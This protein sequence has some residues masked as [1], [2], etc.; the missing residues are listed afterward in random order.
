MGNINNHDKHN[1]EE[2]E[3]KKNVPDKLKKLI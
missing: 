1:F 3:E 2:E